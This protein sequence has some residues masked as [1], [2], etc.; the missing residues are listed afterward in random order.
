MSDAIQTDEIKA[1]LRDLK[2]YLPERDDVTYKFGSYLA[3][4]LE[5]H[6]ELLPMGFKMAA[7]LALYDLEKGVNGFTSEPIRSSLVGYPMMYRLMS[8]EIPN[9]ADAVCPPEFAKEVREFCDHVD[10]QVRKSVRG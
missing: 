9:I 8:M 1:K 10:E 3:E 2:A 4:R 6:P 5:G 7:E